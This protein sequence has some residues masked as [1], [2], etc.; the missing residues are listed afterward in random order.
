M[1]PSIEAIDL[2]RE[3]GVRAAVTQSKKI[4][5]GQNT[6]VTPSARDFPSNAMSW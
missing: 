5:I 6:I 3:S 2:V 4:Y 1:I